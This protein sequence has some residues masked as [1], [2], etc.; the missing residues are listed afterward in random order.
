MIS[1]PWNA[2]ENSIDV[3]FVGKLDFQGAPHGVQ[4]RN[5]GEGPT[6]IDVTTQS[7]IEHR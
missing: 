2:S 4:N 3:I 5:I 7:E 6:K 1:S